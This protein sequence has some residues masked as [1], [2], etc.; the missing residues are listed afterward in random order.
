V[1]WGGPI[2]WGPTL[3]VLALLFVALMPVAARAPEPEVQV[4]PPRSMRE[5][6][7]EPFVGFFQKSR[8]LEIAFFILLYKL[9]DNL[10][11]A[12]VQP[13]LLELHYDAVDVGIASGTVGLVFTIVGTFVGGFLTTRLGVGRA[14]WLF[15]ILQCFAGAGYAVVA[16]VGVHRPLMYAS[17]ALE[18]GASGMGTGAFSVLLLRLTQKRFSATQYAL[19]SSV[20]AM[21]ATIAGPI[22]GAVA[23]AVG[24]RD[25]FLFTIACGVPGLL[26]LQR[27]V[28]WATR[29]LPEE[30]AEM[31][32]A[33]VMGA[34][35]SR[36]GLVMRGA[37]AAVAGAALG[38]FGNA[39]L[40]ALKQMKGGKAF[41]LVASLLRTLDPVQTSDWFETAG[42]VVF[43]LV[44][45]FGLAAYLAARR[46]IRA[47]QAPS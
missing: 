16:M 35:L 12:L 44:V 6:V 41:D 20:F 4:A 33:E 22:A 31:A 32:S 10:A 18:A 8:A 45:G 14:L 30:G 17:V 27:F 47:E 28:P 23:D 7:W 11:V 3:S 43:G 34:A 46:G 36:S 39:L 37:L 26:M 2:G 40:A 42:A 24:W 13:F 9:A 38:L 1:L 15:G 25:F 21:G 5:A 29:D 19:F